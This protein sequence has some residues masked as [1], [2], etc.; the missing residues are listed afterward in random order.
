MDEEALMFSTTRD[1]LF[2][3][4]AVGFVVITFFLS[5][6]LYVLTQVLRN[7]KKV[8][9]DIAEKWQDWSESITMVSHLV[10]TVSKITAPITFIANFLKRRKEKILQ[11]KVEKLEKILEDE[12][13]EK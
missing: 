5:M 13:E 1:I 8:S 9:S 10:R 7:L 6:A 4:L 2:I 11:K 12:E 3:A